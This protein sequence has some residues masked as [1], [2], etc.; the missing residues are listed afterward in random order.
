[1]TPQVSVPMPAYR[2]EAFIAR[3]VASVLVQ[4]VTDFELVIG[5]MT[6]RI[7]SIS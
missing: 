4:T 7:I 2:A 1:M 3:A 5:S 6:G